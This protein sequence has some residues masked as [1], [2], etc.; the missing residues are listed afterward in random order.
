MAAAARRSSVETAFACWRGSRQASTSRSF[1]GSFSRTYRSC[2]S[3]ACEAL[4]QEGALLATRR[5]GVR[6]PGREFDRPRALSRALSAPGP[7]RRRAELEVR[8]LERQAATLAVAR[9]RARAGSVS[10]RRP[11]SRR[12]RHAA[13]ERE[14][15]SARFVI[16]RQ[17]VVAPAPTSRRSVD[18]RTVRGD[19]RPVRSRAGTRIGPTRSSTAGTTIGPDNRIFQSPERRCERRKIS[20][21]AGRRKPPTRSGRNIIREFA[22]AQPGTTAAAWCDGRQ[23][24]AAHELRPRS[25]TISRRQSLVLATAHARRPT[26]R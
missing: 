11:T 12:S 23:R 26:S 16:Y 4:V 2:G 3:S 10:P 13:A 17:R 5:R 24:H 25:V 22:T 7:P 21:I 8:T 9:Y 1:A 6:V 20:K 15:I 18:G 19:R 14:T